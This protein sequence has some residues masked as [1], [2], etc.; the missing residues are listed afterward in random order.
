MPAMATER[1]CSDANKRQDKDTIMACRQMFERRATGRLLA[2]HG[3][4]SGRATGR[5]SP[6]KD[7]ARNYGAGRRTG[8]RQRR[9]AGGHLGRINSWRERERPAMLSESKTGPWS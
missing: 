7:T 4:A 1:N 6:R 2:G 3:P 5:L 9:W 8:R